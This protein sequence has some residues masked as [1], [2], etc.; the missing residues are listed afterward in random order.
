MGAYGAALIAM[1]R[2]SAAVPEIDLD[3][4]MLDAG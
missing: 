4:A 3:P 2:T 1:E